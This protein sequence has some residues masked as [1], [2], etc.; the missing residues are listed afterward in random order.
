MALR[1][2]NTTR[3]YALGKFPALL[4]AVSRELVMLQFLNNQQNK[5]QHSNENFAREVMELF[6]LGRGNYT[7]TDVQEAARAFAGWGYDAAGNY[8]LRA[9]QHDDGVKTFLGQTGRFS[10]ED[11]LRIILAQPAAATFLTTRLYCFLVNNVPNPAHIAPLAASF[12]HSGYDV[13]AL[14]EKCWRPTGFTS[15]PTWALTSKARWSCWPASAVRS[16]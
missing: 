13:A 7:E 9:R 15:R 11:V 4:L 3:Q 10:G 12:R 2:H 14:L 8:Q 5:K 1:L 6:T 16:T